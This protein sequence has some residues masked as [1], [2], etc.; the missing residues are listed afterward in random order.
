MPCTACRSSRDF[1]L[2]RTSSPWIWVFTPFGPSSRI[3]LVIFFAT[4]EDRPSLI[5]P[6]SWYSL[7]EGCGSPSPRSNALS[8]T[9]RRKS[10]DSK[11]ST[12]ALTRSAEFA[13]I[14]TDSPD[15][16]IEAP[17][18]RKSYRCA[19]SLDAWLSALSTSWRSTLLTMSNELSAM[20]GLLFC[21]WAASA[22]EDPG[23]ACYP[24]IRSHATTAGYPSGQRELTVNQPRYASQVRI[25]HPP[26]NA[27]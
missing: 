22:F 23:L 8:E 26:P 11:T 21:W 4:S 17:T 1:A 12:I 5:V 15:H 10:L 2:T 27:N 24:S 14:S 9:P 20:S 3:I 13:F 19:I 7:P 6:A 25:L 18:L 16:S